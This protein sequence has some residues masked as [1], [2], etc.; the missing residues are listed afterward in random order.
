[1]INWKKVIIW[2]ATG[3]IAIVV[4]SVSFCIL[5]TYYERW[6]AKQF[7]EIYTSL[8]PG[9]TTETETRSALHRFG[10]GE[11]STRQGER[12][13]ASQWDENTN[14][15]LVAMGRAY[16]FNNRTLRYLRLGVPA[17]IESI[18]YFRDGILVVKYA[19]F[20]QGWGNCCMIII[21]EA[22]KQFEGIPEAEQNRDGL[23]ISHRWYPDW[24]YLQV[25]PDAYEASRKRAY[26]IDLSCMTSL[27]GC[28]SVEEL[29]PISAK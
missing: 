27:H 2:I 13:S 20:K 6:R 7:L 12:F 26:N 24:I 29:L 21:K 18:L 5:E 22:N 15:R 28:K 19:N 3:S 4:A 16:V 11:E 1:M 25:Y 14:Q 10:H 9:V 17:E 8:K 23:R